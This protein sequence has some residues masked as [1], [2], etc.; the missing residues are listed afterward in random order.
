M[1]PLPE[2]AYLARIE[3]RLEALNDLTRT[4]ATRQ[5]LD[6]LRKEVVASAVLEPQLS[7]LRTQIQQV[8]KAREG[9][10]Q[11]FEKRIA[12]M[13]AEQ[14]SRSDRF[15]AKMSPAIAAIALLVTLV[16]FLSHYHFT[17]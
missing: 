1:Q 15:W 2:N 7:I 12:E 6:A 14:V 10:R 9:D 16:E 3:H 5:D 17:P 4:L 13:E 8:E 11:A